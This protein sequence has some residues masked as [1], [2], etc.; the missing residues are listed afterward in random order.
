MA[1]RVTFHDHVEIGSWRGRF[2][3]NR[4]PVER[5]GIAAMGGAIEQRPFVSVSVGP[6]I[7]EAAAAFSRGPV[8]EEDATDRGTGFLRA[9]VAPIPRA[10]IDITPP[11]TE[12]MDEGPPLDA[13]LRV[14]APRPGDGAFERALASYRRGSGGGN[15]KG[16]S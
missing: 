13:P 2:G 15:L 12:A 9:L 10:W 11:R 3:P 5:L 16:G 1:L 14:E 4:E 8:P 6:S 7:L